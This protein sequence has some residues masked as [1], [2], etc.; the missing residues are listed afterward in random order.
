MMGA[1]QLVAMESKCDDLR[2]AADEAEMVTYNLHLVFL[3]F[4]LFMMLYQID[5]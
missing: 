5:L 2:K 3:L 1:D 4:I